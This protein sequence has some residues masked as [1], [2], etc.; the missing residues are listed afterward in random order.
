MRQIKND[1]LAMFRFQPYQRVII[2]VF[3]HT[4]LYRLDNRN[5]DSM[6]RAAAY[7][8][9]QACSEL[10]CKARNT[11]SMHSSEHCLC[12]QLGTLHLCPARNTASVHS[13]ELG[14]LHLC[15]ARNMPG[16]LGTLQLGTLSPNFYCPGGSQY[17]WNFLL[18]IFY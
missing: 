18:V 5:W 15:P 13:S 4:A 17:Q 10:L 6:F 16:L 1:D 11:A 9:N 12:A 7:Q 3:N 8:A 2:I 14:T